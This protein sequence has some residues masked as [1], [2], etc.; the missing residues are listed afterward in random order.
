MRELFYK[1]ALIYR[2]LKARISCKLVTKKKATR[3]R[4]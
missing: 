2:K 1:I 4:R 3:N